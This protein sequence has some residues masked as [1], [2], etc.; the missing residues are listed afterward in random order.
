MALFL[1][2]ISF[3]F[4]LESFRHLAIHKT[5]ILNFKDMNNFL[6]L[7]YFLNRK[8]N[9]KKFSTTLRILLDLKKEG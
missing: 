6:L 7:F 8:G 2:E 3:F 1:F 5:G 9:L 4:H